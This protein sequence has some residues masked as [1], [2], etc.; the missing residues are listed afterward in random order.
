MCNFRRDT[1]HQQWCLQ[2]GRIA[3]FSTS[4]LLTEPLF[5]ITTYA[6]EIRDPG[7]RSQDLGMLYRNKKRCPEESRKDSFML[8]TLLLLQHGEICFTC[9]KDSEVSTHYS[10]KP[11]I[12][13]AP[14]APAHSCGPKPQDHNGPALAQ[15]KAWPSRP[16]HWPDRR[17]SG[18]RVPEGTLVP[19]LLPWSQSVS[20]PTHGPRS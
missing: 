3:V 4:R 10:R 19:G 20:T 13:Q 18:A 16:R 15:H 6:W 11:S 2:D 7:Q 5:W 8:P 17:D 9:G 1:S 12:R 14:M